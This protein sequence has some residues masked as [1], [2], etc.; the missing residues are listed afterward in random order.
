MEPSCLWDIQPP[1]ALIFAVR[2]D[3]QPTDTKGALTLLRIYPPRFLRRGYR[4]NNGDRLPR[5]DLRAS[6]AA[7]SASGSSAT[8]RAQGPVHIV[9]SL[10]R[11][12]QPHGQ[13]ARTGYPN[14]H[15]ILI[16]PSRNATLDRSAVRLFLW[17]ELLA[18]GRWMGSCSSQKV[19]WPSEAGV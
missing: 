8:A 15:C 6:S 17:K 9:Q 14:P 10:C 5:L 16:F 4:G 2:L 3:P 13:L 19:P 1:L 11:T 12:V 7:S 18:V